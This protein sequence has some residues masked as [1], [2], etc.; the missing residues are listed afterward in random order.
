MLTIILS[1]VA[2]TGVVLGAVYMLTVF[3]RV[4]FGPVTNDKNHKLTDVSLREFCV[5]APLVFFIFF[6][7]LF[8]NT[9]LKPMHASVG[10][11]LDNTACVVNDEGRRMCL[12][13]RV[14]DVRD[15]QR[16]DLKRQRGRRTAAAEPLIRSTADDKTVAHLAGER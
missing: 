11:L 13:D 15:R 1:A 2:A 16:L 8:P 3:R 10:N 5:V 4:F 14:D 9:F 6:I 7:G 12:A